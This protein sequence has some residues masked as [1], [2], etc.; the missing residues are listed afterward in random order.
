MIR[1]TWKSIAMLA[2]GGLL[3][4][5]AGVL[6]ETPAGAQESLDAQAALDELL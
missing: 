2:A 5:G 4:L 6:H 1:R 3:A